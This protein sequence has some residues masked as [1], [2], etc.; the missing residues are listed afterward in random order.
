MSS[1]VMSATVPAIYVCSA[2]SADV[3]TLQERTDVNVH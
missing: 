2:L 1:V 3:L